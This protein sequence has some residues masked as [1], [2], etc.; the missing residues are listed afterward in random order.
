MKHVKALLNLDVK[1]DYLTDDIIEL[2]DVI[3]DLQI[4]INKAKL[5]NRQIQ[6]Y[7]I[8]KQGYKIQDI[9][10]LLNTTHQNISKA[11]TSIAKKLYAHTKKRITY[12]NRLPNVTF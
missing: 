8:Y 11:L 12:K 1:I 6:I 2:N 5:T 10:D 9:A 4:L 7:N 3:Y